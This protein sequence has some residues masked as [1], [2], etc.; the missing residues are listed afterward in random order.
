MDT[1][2]NT[3]F[4][5][6]NFWESLFVK[7]VSQWRGVAHFEH[8]VLNTKN[9]WHLLS[10]SSVEIYWQ[11]ITGEV[12]SFMTCCRRIPSCTTRWGRQNKVARPPPFIFMLPSWVLI[13]STK[14]QWY[15]IYLIH[16]HYATFFIW[17]LWA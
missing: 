1:K 15:D 3:Y 14:I 11:I 8:L 16:L 13:P 17:I 7:N 12:W 5:S 4:D 2:S 9:S 10:H 6:R